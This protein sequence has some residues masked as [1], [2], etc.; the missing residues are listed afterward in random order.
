MTT[1]AQSED[2]DQTQRENVCRFLVSSFA[3]ENLRSDP[4]VGA[5]WAECTGVTG[6]QYSAS[7]VALVF[8]DDATPSVTSQFHHGMIPIVDG[9]ENVVRIQVAVDDAIVVQMIQPLDDLTDDKPISS[10]VVPPLDEVVQCPI[11]QLSH[12][13]SIYNK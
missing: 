5:K 3:V 8:R 12:Q 6:H 7:Q 11:A 9:K 13:K 4:T 2:K 10:D 1:S